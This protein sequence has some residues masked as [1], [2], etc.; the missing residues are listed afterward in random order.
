M[1]IEKEYDSFI[2]KKINE[3]SQAS[4]IPILGV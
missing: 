2:R 1:R 3:K 4:K